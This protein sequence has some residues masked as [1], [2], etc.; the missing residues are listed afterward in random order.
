MRMKCVPRCSKERNINN[1]KCT[2]TH[3]QQSANS[4]RVSCKEKTYRKKT[5]SKH[6]VSRVSAFQHALVR[7]RAER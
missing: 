2:A 5:S 6:R 3:V 1:V 7:L 4:T